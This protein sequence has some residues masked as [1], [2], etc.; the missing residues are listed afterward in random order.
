MTEPLTP[1][2]DHLHSHLALSRELLAVAERENT[3]LRNPAPVDFAQFNQERQRLLPRV[4]QSTARLHELSQT[5]QQLPP[6]ER[7]R[8]AAIAALLQQNQDLTLRVLMLDR[9]NEQVLLRRGLIPASAVS[10]TRPA[11]PPKSTAPGAP[12][13]P[14]PS[15]S[16]PPA[17]PAPGTSYVANIYRRA[18][19]PQ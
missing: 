6:A 18:G 11:P 14:A 10:A 4:Q 8:H 15:I 1:L 9:E 7:R 3:A 17:S 19:K 12:A 2:H 16:A 13:K 5:W